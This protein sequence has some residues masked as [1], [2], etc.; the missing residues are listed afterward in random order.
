MNVLFYFYFEY[1]FMKCYY[2][3]IWYRVIEI[4][5]SRS[6]EFCLRQFRKQFINFDLSLN[7]LIMINFSYDVIYF[8]VLDCFQLEF[9]EFWQRVSEFGGEVDFWQSNLQQFN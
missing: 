6:Q 5:V 2:G 7:C 9:G 4:E 1:K 3:Y 8:V